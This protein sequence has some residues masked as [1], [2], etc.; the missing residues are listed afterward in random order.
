MI[1]VIIPTLNASKYI[2]SILEKLKKQT[3][4]PDEIIVIDS[5]SDDDTLKIASTFHVKTHKIPR[6][7][8]DHGGTRNLAVKIS[9]GNLL[10]FLT[11]DAIPFD[12][13]LIENLIRP[14]NDPCIA[15]SFGRQVPRNNAKITEIFTRLFNYPDMPLVKNIDSIKTLGIKTF[16][17]SNVCSAIKKREFIEVGGFPEVTIFNEDMILAS[18]LILKGYKIAYEPRAIVIHSHNYRLTHQFKRYFDMGVSYRDNPCILKYAKTYKEGL[19]FLKNEICFLFKNKK[20]EKFPYV[21]FEAFTKYCGF[22]LGMNYNAIPYSFRRRLSMN[23]NYWS[24][25][26]INSNRR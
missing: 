1:S 8:F 12:K 14:L 9:S 6:N 25:K 23:S 26:Q 3:C 22:K 4:I 21:I 18:K 5:S 2:K 11:Q 13:T 10:I 19:N 16:F 7:I 17:F 15:A 20:Y 24:N